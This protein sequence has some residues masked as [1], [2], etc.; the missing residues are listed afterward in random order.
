MN[1]KCPVCGQETNSGSMHCQYCGSPFTNEQT[2]FSSSQKCKVC[3]SSIKPGDVFCNHC[4]TRVGLTKSSPASISQEPHK[5]TNPV[6]LKTMI[7][8]GI[9]LLCFLAFRSLHIGERSNAPLPEGSLSSGSNYSDGN[10]SD[11]EE[12]NQD[13]I[14]TNSQNEDDSETSQDTNNLE[15]EM[16]TS[17]PS[18]ADLGM[19]IPSDALIIKGHSYYLYDN[20]CKDWDDVLNF[21]E[22]K[23]GY[24]VVINDSEENEL[25]FEY[26]RSMNRN[27]SLIGY[28]DRDTEGIWR[29]PDGKDSDFT[30][31]GTNNEGELEPNSD[32]PD[33]DYAQLDINMHDGHWNDCA[34]AWDTASFICEWDSTN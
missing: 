14:S 34:F 6:I 29:W 11:P 17:L 19:K 21:C 26:M 15:D 20:D 12:D 13:T 28:T 3:G 31:W 9:L 8:V 33:E 16:G 23:G 4:G 24:P 27:A 7:V 10:D 5:K 2:E 25:L 18:A 32:S 1:R 30:D 22:S